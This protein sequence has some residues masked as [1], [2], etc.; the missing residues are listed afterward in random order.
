MAA[1][2]PSL[3]TLAIECVQAIRLFHKPLCTNANSMCALCLALENYDAGVGAKPAL[4]RCQDIVGRRVRL[5]RPIETRGGAEF[6]VGTE[7][8]CAGTVRGRFM[9][10]NVAGKPAAW[11]SGVERRDFELLP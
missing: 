10:Q 2:T 3:L 5:V 6:A 4:M 11:V 8:H 9:L 7:L 1:K